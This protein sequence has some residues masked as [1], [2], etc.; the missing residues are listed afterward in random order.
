IIVEI[1]E[2]RPVALIDLGD[3]Y[4]LDESGTAFKKVDMQDEFDLPVI[5]GFSMRDFAK[6]S[7]AVHK[8]LEDVF[9]FLTVLAERNDRFRLENIAEINADPVR[10]ITLSTRDQNIQV[11]VGT[12]DYRAKFNRLGRVLAHLKIRGDDKEIV[13]VNLECGPRVIIRSN[14]KSG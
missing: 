3:I 11:K 8:E 5:T 9:N 1:E 13:Y 6:R 7:K 10:G 14:I 2:H 4:Y 12:G